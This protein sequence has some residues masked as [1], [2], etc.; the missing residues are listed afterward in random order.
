MEVNFI[1]NKQNQM[2]HISINATDMNRQ[3]QMINIHVEVMFKNETFN[4]PKREIY[5]DELTEKLGAVLE[6]YFDTYSYE[7]FTNHEWNINM[8]MK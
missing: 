6:E 7:T 8:R 1:T 4:S 3:M 5:M 2:P